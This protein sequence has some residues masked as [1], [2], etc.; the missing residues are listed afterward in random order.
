M[1]THHGEDETAV[2]KKDVNDE[3][4]V[5]MTAKGVRLWW[6]R[7]SWQLGDVTPEEAWKAGRKEEVMRYAEG[8]RE[9]GG[10]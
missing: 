8:G 3:V 7:K 4:G 5:Y 9:M 10:T 2:N 1:G 6:R